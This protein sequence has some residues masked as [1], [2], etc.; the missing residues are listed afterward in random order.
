MSRV[1]I[2]AP[3]RVLVVE[4]YRDRVEALVRDGVILTEFTHASNALEALDLLD[5]PW[6]VVF[7]DHDLETYIAD[8]YPKEV[9]GADVARAMVRSGWMPKAVIIHSMNPAGAKEMEDILKE[10]EFPVYRIPITELTKWK[11]R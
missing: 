5:R 4:D 8:P 11:L 1:V 3:N 6:D 9:T 10:A 7:L 2:E